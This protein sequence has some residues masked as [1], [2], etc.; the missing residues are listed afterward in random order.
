MMTLSIRRFA[1]VIGLCLLVGG[2]GLARGGEGDA[3][4][5]GWAAAPCPADRAV[6]V[7]LDLWVVVD[8][9]A[10]VREAGWFA[11]QLAEANRT[12]AAVDA[13]FSVQSVRALP[14]GVAQV[15]TRA[16]RDAIGQGRAGDGAVAVFLVAR[17]DDVDREGEQ[18]RGVHWRE[19]EKG[20]A[21]SWI[22]MSAI[23]PPIVLAHE[24]GHRF[25][26]RHGRAP[27]SIMNKT[28]RTEPDPATWG[29][30]KR[31]QRTLRR[32]LLRFAAGG[33]AP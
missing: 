8:G 22:V 28:P 9:D 7:P 13:G 21:R 29:F 32:E 4:V 26:L 17:L 14:V 11:G 10:P 23:A 15:A 1:A 6:C 27:D 16:D 25:G 30:T 12:F 19:G 20:G 5:P 24:L 31:E 18:I 2:D 33:R 3:G